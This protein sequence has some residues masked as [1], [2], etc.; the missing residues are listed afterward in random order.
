MNT[1][2]A[3]REIKMSTLMYR[4]LRRWRGIVV[5]GLLAARALGGYKGLKLR[6]SQ[7]GQEQETDA[8]IAQSED[9]TAPG[10]SGSS[11]AET[12]RSLLKKLKKRQK[13]TREYLDNSILASIDPGHEAQA[14]VSIRILTEDPD[15]T[16]ALQ[17]AY[18]NFL[19]SGIDWSG[20]AAD[21]N[22]KEEYL[23]ELVSFGDEWKESPETPSGLISLTVKHK[24][25][26]DAET[27]MKEL[28]CQMENQKAE[29]VQ[30]A[31][32]HTVS[33][34]AVTTG[35]FSDPQLEIWMSEQLKGYAEIA[36]DMDRLEAEKDTVKNLSSGKTGAA[37]SASAVV[38]YALA[39]FVLGIAAGI[40]L[41]MIGLVCRRRILS[42]REWN[43]TFG[44]RSL[45]VIPD[46]KR[47]R[48]PLDRLVE[49]LD[50]DKKNQAEE[51]TRYHLAVE[52]IHR[53]GR[54]LRTEPEG[55]IKTILLTGDV[56]LE[57][58]KETAE[59]LARAEKQGQEAGRTWLCGQNLSSDPDTLAKADQSDA[60]ILVEK[61]EHSRYSAVQ[62]DV[63]QMITWKIPILGTITL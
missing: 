32:D 46:K 11:G 51:E 2:T 47:R 16:V 53:C 14:N 35:Y 60:V 18:E 42:A 61:T 19:A 36:A 37:S 20:L 43:S 23:S 22:T 57:E 17:K 26:S 63:E 6:N 59:K 45:A 29:I 56:S 7:E 49:K 33:V 30:T 25:T 55:Q 50:G 31:G 1:E 21:L 40:L 15:Q 34:G 10:S 3:E 13:G 48:G 39:G 52:N 38:K 4:V 58:L 5:F 44:L 41:C 54:M 8:V 62:E 28:L 27:I 9:G 12:Y 24:T